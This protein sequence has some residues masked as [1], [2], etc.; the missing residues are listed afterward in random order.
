M[1]KT[2][3]TIAAAA[4]AASFAVAPAHAQD[5]RVSVG[6][7]DLDIASAA[8]AETLADRIEA[9]IGG[10]CGRSTNLRDLKAV[11]VCKQTMISDAVVQLNGRGATQTAQYLS[12]KG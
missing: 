4:L 1:T 12:D 9:R 8:G 7:S 5:L 10:A 6:Y 2:I 11:A 3:F